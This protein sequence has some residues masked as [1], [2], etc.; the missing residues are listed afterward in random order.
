MEVVLVLS[1]EIV[2]QPGVEGQGNADGIRALFRAVQIDRPERRAEIKRRTNSVVHEGR[3]DYE[4]RA[5][6]KCHLDC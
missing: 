3:A 5:A 2:R 4:K 6:M 1:T